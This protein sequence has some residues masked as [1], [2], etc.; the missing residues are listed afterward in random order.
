MTPV[1]LYEPGGPL[2]GVSEMLRPGGLALTERGLALCNLPAGA[3]ILDVGCGGA[4]AI[5]HLMTRYG[6]MTA[7][8]DLSCTSLT[9]GKR[10][11]PALRL[12]QAAS[13]SLPLASCRLDAVLAEC[14]LSMAGG[15]DRALKEFRRALQPGGWL[16]LNDL[17][18]R[19]PDGSRQSGLLAKAELLA[20]IEAFG[21]NTIAWEDHSDELRRF[22]AQLIWAGRSLA[23]LGFDDLAC[24]RL[25][26]YLLVARKCDV[27]SAP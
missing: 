17:Y 3:F 14:S 23:H 12:V 13:G 2:E 27:A 8:I 21:F 22:V 19:Q 11:N 9:L 6:Y 4:A 5:E 10:R 20:K 15:L 7:G 16:I 25:G 18:A 1:C 24:A 26:Y